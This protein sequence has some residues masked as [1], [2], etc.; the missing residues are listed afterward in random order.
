MDLFEFA[1]TGDPVLLQAIDDGFDVDKANENGDTLVMLA[2]Y[3][4]HAELVRGLV[5]RGADVNRP[6]AKGLVPLA[7]AVFKG[8]EDLILTLLRAGAD[9]DAGSP[10]VRATAAMYGRTLPAV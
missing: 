6:N 3:H 8:H 7:G 2:T 10:T 5:A 1:R 4:G 9:P